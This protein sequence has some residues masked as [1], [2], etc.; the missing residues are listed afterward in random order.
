M[1]EQTY[2]DTFHQLAAWCAHKELDSIA[3]T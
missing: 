2:V 1:T 3:Q